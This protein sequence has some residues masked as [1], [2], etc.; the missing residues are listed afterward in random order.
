[1]LTHFR[2]VCEARGAAWVYVDDLV[3]IGIVCA[4]V[5]VAIIVLNA[6]LRR[7]IHEVHS[8]KAAQETEQR[9]K[10]FVGVFRGLFITAALFLGFLAV[11]RWYNVD[12]TP[13]L[14][15]AGIA[16]V[17]VGFGA[18][19]LIKDV[20]AGFFIL[21]EDQFAVGDVVEICGVSGD[22]EAMTLRTTVLRDMNGC[23]HVVPN[24][25]IGVV[26]NYTRGWSRVDLKIAVSRDEDAD[27]VIAVL[28]EELER[29]AAEPAWSAKL[30]GEPRVLGMDVF[31]EH[32]FTIRLLIRTRPG[33]QWGVRREF[34]KRVKARFDAED[35]RAPYPYRVV[36]GGPTI[37]SA[38]TRRP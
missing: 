25:Q 26:T 13:F 33:E 35:I 8:R 1:M 30:D 7:V 5:V 4:I 34:R 17:I 12:L 20:L 29:F 21:M 19:S 32:S 3:F 37:A 11:M 2:R 14:A 16:G 36:T 9:A 18:Q 38:K 22:V 31:D 10:T 28:R 23:A 27:R 24:G 15:S 6:I